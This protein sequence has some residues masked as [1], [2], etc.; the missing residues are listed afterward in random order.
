MRAV[1]HPWAV[2]SP[3]AVVIGTLS[4]C[5]S[6]AP[7]VG[8][9][10]SQA[11]NTAI[12]FVLTHNKLPLEGGTLRQ[13]D[14]ATQRVKPI[15]AAAA[16]GA[17]PSAQSGATTHIDG[18]K[19]YVPHQ[20]DYPMEFLATVDT[21]APDIGTF[22]GVLFFTMSAVDA[23]WL[24]VDYVVLPPAT[25]PPVFATDAEGYAEKVNPDSFGG[26]AK[27]VGLV[28]VTYV[29]D[30]TPGAVVIDDSFAPGPL[31]QGARDQISGVA[32]LLSRAG[33]AVDF[34]ATPV[35][36]SL[37]AYKTKDGNAFAIFDYAGEFALAGK[38]PGDTFT[39][40]PGEPQQRSGL[41]AGRYKNLTIHL[42]GSTAIIDPAGSAG[43]LQAIGDSGDIV[44]AG[45]G[46]L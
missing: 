20:T 26:F 19:A 15:A 12:T 44:A 45:G 8:P 32:G 43:K 38:N 24:A 27:N 2:L 5:G 40:G 23:H 17:A 1:R 36:G 3:L 21:T 41:T 42:G 9:T 28:P 46:S 35:N 11:Q 30:L 7:V 13:L 31:P 39:W 6:G 25:V 18:V 14:A 33:I 37:A 16:A 22:H 29:H 34:N 4:A 10:P